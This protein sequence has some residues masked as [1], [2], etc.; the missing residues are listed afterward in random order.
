MGCCA[1]LHR[2]TSLLLYITGIGLSSYAF[3]VEIQKELDP[4]YVALCDFSEEIS[5]SRVFNSKYGKGFGLVTL[6]TGDEKHFLNQPNALFGII[7]YSVLGML[8]LCGGSSRF[9]AHLQFFSFLIANGMSCYLGYILY[10]V[11]K[12]LC[13]VCISTYAV[14]FLLLILSWCK[15]RSLRKKASP[16]DNFGKYEPGLPSFSGDSFK[17][18]I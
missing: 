4:N 2:W 6:I 12:D 17:K 13:V 8:F 18:N 3:Y 9:L 15:K 7:F 1:F 5:C 14:N 10:F 16:M 11:L